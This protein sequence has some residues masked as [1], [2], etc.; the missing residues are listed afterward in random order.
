VEFTSARY[1][2]MMMM[3]Q[4]SPE[5]D[6][7][8]TALLAS[9]LDTHALAARLAPLARAGDVITLSGDLGAGKTTFA[10]GFI[11]ALFVTHDLPLEDVP[12]PTF[13]LVQEYQLP[14][15]TLY[16]I[17]LYRV[18]SQSELF[19]LGLEDFFSEGVSL[20]EWP[21][22]LGSLLPSDRLDVTLRQGLPGEPQDHRQVDVTAYGDWKD[23][24]HPGVLNG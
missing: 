16:H 3:A 5:L 9:P 7:A 10:R 14:L 11:N 18:E 12:S 23:R 21:D 2:Q 8:F 22:R 15:F 17:D 1:K 19:E 6:G 24:L 20:I 13:T 4:E